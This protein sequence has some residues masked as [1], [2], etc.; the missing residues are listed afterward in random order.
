MQ[1]AWPVEGWKDPAPH[2]EQ[3]ATAEAAENF[4]AAHSVQELAP[5]T[6]PVLVIEPAAQAVHAATFDVAEYLP[7]AHGVQLVAS[8][9]APV[10]VVEPA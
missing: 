6:P 8:I 4:P 2:T 5:R 3:A 9:A 1:A 7:T 10:L